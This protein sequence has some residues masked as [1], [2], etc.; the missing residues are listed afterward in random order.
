MRFEVHGQAY[1]L[2]MLPVGGV[3]LFAP[4]PNGLE[5]I[6]IVHDDPEHVRGNFTPPADE[7]H[8]IV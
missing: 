6:P 8:R 7:G 3:G 1:Y 5:Q 2:A 4:T